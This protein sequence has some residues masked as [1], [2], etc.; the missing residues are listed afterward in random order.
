MT[1]FPSQSPALT[2]AQEI[3]E[4][5][6]RSNAHEVT[7]A[8]LM[9][10]EEFAELVSSMRQAQKQYFADRKQQSLKEAIRLEQLVDEQLSQLI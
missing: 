5:Q 8:A 2:K 9:E 6:L 3:S 10:F 1:H 7:I 4:H